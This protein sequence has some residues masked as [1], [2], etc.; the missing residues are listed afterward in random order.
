MKTDKKNI[1]VTGATGFVGKCL[2]NSLLEKG[3]TVF[4]LSRANQPLDNQPVKIIKGDITENID[5][6]E[7]ISTIYH[8]AGL[9]SDSNALSDREHME[10]VNIGGTKTMVETALKAKCRLIHLGTAAVVGDVNQDVIDENIVCHPNSL[11]EKSKLDA[12]NLVRAGIEKGLKAQILRPSFIFGMGRSPLED[13]FLQLVKAIKVGQYKAIRRGM[14]FYNIIHVN[15]VV[16]ALNIL[17]DDAIPNGGVYFI[18]TPVTFNRFAEIVKLSVTGIR[19]KPGN[20][21]YAIAFLGAMALTAISSLTGRKMPL[22]L[23]RLRTLT[24]R[25]I[26]SQEN[27]L[28]MTRYRPLHSVEELISQICVEYNKMGLLH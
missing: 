3:L 16:R 6:P 1:L 17:D 15:E 11:Y 25:M 19:K 23:S 8:C 27:L 12:E 28:K 26:Y 21:P 14:G 10:K 20:L 13:P 5:L 9:W 22:T 7:D 4:A 18:N 24:N 2:V